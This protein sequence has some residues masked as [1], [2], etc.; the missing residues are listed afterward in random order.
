[1]NEV[2]QSWEAEVP[3]VSLDV[4]PSDLGKGSLLQVNVRLPEGNEYVQFGR[5]HYA[6]NNTQHSLFG[7]LKDHCEFSKREEPTD[8]EDALGAMAKLFLDDPKMRALSFTGRF[9]LKSLPTP[10]KGWTKA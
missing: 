10:P 1:M 7:F 5:A 8:L 6:N 3:G 9:E 2:P 4:R